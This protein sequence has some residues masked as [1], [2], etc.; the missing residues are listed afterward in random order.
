MQAAADR[1]PWALLPKCID[2]F[3]DENNPVSGDVLVEQ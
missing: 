1:E 2:D 3:I